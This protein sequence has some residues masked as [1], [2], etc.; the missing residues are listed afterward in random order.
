MQSEQHVDTLHEVCD[1]EPGWPAAEPA[2]VVQGEL[3]AAGVGGVPALQRYKDGGAGGIRNLYD[4]EPWAAL[5]QQQRQSDFEP[6]HLLERE[7]DG[8]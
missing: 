7:Y 2:E 4:D 3:P 6:A 5:V 1:G 8:Q